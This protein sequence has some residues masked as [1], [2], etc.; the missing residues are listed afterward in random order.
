MS[1]NSALA[2]PQSPGVC[3]PDSADDVD[4][5]LLRIVRLTANAS[6]TSVSALLLR[7]E[8]MFRICAVHGDRRLLN[9]TALA[10]AEEA[11]ASAK[12]RFTTD[13]DPVQEEQFFVACEPVVDL[14][15]DVIGVLVVADYGSRSGSPELRSMMRDLAAVAAEALD[16][17]AA[18]PRGAS[19]LDAVFSIVVSTLDSINTGALELKDVMRLVIDQAVRLTSGYGAAVGLVD[20]DGITFRAASEAVKSVR[21]TRLDMDEA[22]AGTCVETGRMMLCRDVEKDKTLKHEVY[23]RVGARSLATVPLNY[24]AVTMGVLTV[25]GDRVNAFS[26]ADVRILEQLAMLIAVAVERSHSQQALRESEGR[27]QALIQHTAEAIYFACPHSGRILEA[28]PAFFALLGYDPS[29]LEAL[30]II[31]FVDHSSGDISM[32]LEQALADRLIFLE[33]RWRTKAGK[34]VD[35]QATI[36]VINHDDRELLFVVARDITAHKAAEASRRRSERK[37]RDLFERANVPILIFRPENEVIIDANHQAVLDYGFEREDL[38]GMS[39]KSLTA[40]V[41]RGEQEMHHIITQGGTQNFETLHHRKDGSPIHLLVSCSLIDYEGDTAVLMF[42]RDITDRKHTERLLSESESRLRAVTENALDLIGIIDGRGRIKYMSGPI[43]ELTGLNPRRVRSNL[44]FERVHPDDL[45]RVR[46]GLIESVQHP[47][48]LISLE[49]R[50][51]HGDGSWRDLSLKGRNLQNTPGVEGILVSM[52]D[53][54]QRKQ[55]EAELVEAKEKAEEMARLKSAFLAN[56]SHEIRTPLTA[57]LGFAD[58]LAREVTGEHREFAELIQEGGQRL[59]ET[60]NSVLDLAR[61][62]AGGF[63]PLLETIDTS[64]AVR[65]VTGVFDSLALKKNVVLKATLPAEPTTVRADRGALSRVLQNLIGNAIKFTDHGSVT[66]KIAAEHPHVRIDVI[67]TGT[68]IDSEFLPH[69]FVEFKQESTGLAR[70]HEGSGLGLTITKRLVDLMDGSIEVESKKGEGS[71]FTVR[72]P[73]S[74][75]SQEEKTEIVGVDLDD[76]HSDRMRILVVEDN[77]YTRLLVDRLLRDTYDVT[78]ASNAEQAYAIAT[79]TGFDVLLMDINL[80]EGQNGLEV[81]QEFRKD[82]RFAQTPFVALTAYAMPEDRN[83]F[84]DAGF[85]HYLSKPFT[86]DDLRRTI[87]EALSD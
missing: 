66:V 61:L 76:A 78:S 73:M 8:A 16:T 82:D 54:T 42:G 33:R 56:M 87:A 59:S 64:E 40:D 53:V 84:L 80:G 7:N 17:T 79:E 35:V 37:Y 27:Y 47:E 34:R 13:V 14:R 38:I 68:G 12:H 32:R 69:L 72:L 81:M 10:V 71:R 48:R 57:I 70:S 58:V 85:D 55:F 23:E 1:S 5:G 4:L 2:V 15:D 60:L 29:E 39:L 63:K 26:Q 43:E 36:S 49:F 21:G 25:F 18:T 50:F 74:E 3:S 11:F 52:R 22:H 9:E 19:P 20:D 51:Q 83:R 45:S 86:K 41:T 65:S 62:E 44:A 30:T 77:M 28:N 31:D 46:R 75:V 67:D 24:R 6:G